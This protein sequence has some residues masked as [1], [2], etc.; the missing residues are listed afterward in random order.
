VT[1]IEWLS[2][3][4]P[5]GCA[6]VLKGMYWGLQKH[7]RQG[8]DAATERLFIVSGRAVQTFPGRESLL[9]DGRAGTIRRR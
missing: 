9:Q 8:S 6:T 3:P 2:S 5:D 1:G 7:F 4:V